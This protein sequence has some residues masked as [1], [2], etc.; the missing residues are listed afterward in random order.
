MRTS[1]VLLALIFSGCAALPGPPAGTVKRKESMIY[2]GMLFAEADARL[3]AHGA[4]A[5]LFPMALS[6]ED[7]DQGKE[8]HYYTL[9]SGAVMAMVSRPGPAGRVVGSLSV[10]TYVPKSWDSKTDPERDRFFDSFQGHEEYD[11]GVAP[12]PAAPLSGL[13]SASAMP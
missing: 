4:A 1:L 13:A 5:T 3:K 10:S 8:L 7:Y 12:E 6:P 11:L 9:R 2:V